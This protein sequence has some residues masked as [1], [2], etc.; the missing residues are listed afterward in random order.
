[1]K[2]ADNMRIS[3]ST[4]ANQHCPDW[5]YFFLFMKEHFKILAFMFIHKGLKLNR[6]I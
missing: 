3:Y 1:M 5:K 6:I 4:E 2:G